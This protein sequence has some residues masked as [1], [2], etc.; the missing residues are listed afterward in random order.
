MCLEDQPGVSLPPADPAMLRIDRPLSSRQ[1]WASAL[2]STVTGGCLGLAGIQSRQWLPPG[3]PGRDAPHP[4]RHLNLTTTCRGGSPEGRGLEIDHGAG[5]GRMSLPPRRDGPALAES[6]SPGHLQR[7][8]QMGREK[9]V[10]DF[11]AKW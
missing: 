5:Q 3:E 9:R 10:T 11:P 6:P 2:L 4:T 8:K 7:G 1:L